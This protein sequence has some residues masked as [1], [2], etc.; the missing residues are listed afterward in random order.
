MVCNLKELRIYKRKQILKYI[1]QIKDDIE[2]IDSVK[3]HRTD[4]LY[5]VDIRKEFTV[6]LKE[7]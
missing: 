6:V 7:K 3:G 1:I 2:Y 4:Q 5:L